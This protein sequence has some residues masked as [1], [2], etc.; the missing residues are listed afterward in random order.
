MS[1]ETVYLICTS[2]ATDQPWDS[3]LTSTGEQPAHETESGGLTVRVGQ[4]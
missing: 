3:A 4:R 1:D 2:P